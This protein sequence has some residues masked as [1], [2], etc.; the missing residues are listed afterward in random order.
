MIEIIGVEHGEEE[1]KRRSLP[2]NVRQIGECRGKQKIY[3][4]DYVVTYLN[5]LSKPDQVCARGAILFGGTF[6]TEEGPAV[7]ISGAIEAGNL[8]LDM[9]ETF[10]NEMIWYELMEKGGQYFPGQDV[11]GWFLSR[12]GYSVEINQKMI[13]IHKKNFPGE[14]K[15]LY[16]IDALEKEDAMYLCENQQMTRQKGYYI[17]YEKNNAMQEYMLEIERGKRKDSKE[18]AVE[19][20]IRGDRKIVNTYR[21]MSQYRKNSKKQDVKIKAVRAACA[22]LIF[23]MGIYIAGKL[24]SRFVNMGFEDYTIATF[25]TVKSVFMPE[26]SGRVEEDIRQGE[27]GSVSEG[28]SLADKEGKSTTIGK[29]GNSTDTGKEEKTSKETESDE[30]EETAA[31]PKPLYYVVKKGDTLVSISRKMY[32][33]D[34]H[35]RQIAEANNLS[36]A[37]QI[38][39]GQKILIP[40][41]E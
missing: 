40:S 24:G 2:K 34:K 31:F 12:M 29:E 10:F 32:S 14:F 5:K 7:F 37:D 27:T 25:Q 28:E 23:L 26:E 22:A 38:Y 36:N 16:M 8:E 6:D 1:R 3:I 41:M 9:D 21:R 35:A 18:K 13:E 11:V 30:L 20:E 17:Y 4:E 19:N 39:V 33:S 15:V